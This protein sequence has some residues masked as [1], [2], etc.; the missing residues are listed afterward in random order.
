MFTTADGSLLPSLSSQENI[1]ESAEKCLEVQ[2][3][4][5]LQGGAVWG[6]GSSGGSMPLCCPCK[7]HEEERSS[8]FTKEATEARRS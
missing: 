2:Q 6:V 7:S 3:T 8:C 5:A 4:F 1:K